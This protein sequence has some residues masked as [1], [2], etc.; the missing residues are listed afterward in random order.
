MHDVVL[1]AT[2]YPHSL[3]RQYLP[4][5]SGPDSWYPF[6]CFRVACE[7]LYGKATCYAAITKNLQ[8]RDVEFSKEEQ[9]MVV[10]QVG[11]V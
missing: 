2:L 7:R 5:I 10:T 9:R 11:A 4:Q 8:K 1:L 3:A 6:E